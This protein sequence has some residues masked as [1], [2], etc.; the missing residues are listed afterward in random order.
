MTIRYQKDGDT[1][2]VQVN[3]DGATELLSAVRPNDSTAGA[4][5]KARN[6][7]GTVCI[8]GDKVP[9]DVIVRAKGKEYV[10]DSG[11]TN[12]PTAGLVTP[13]L[14]RVRQGTEIDEPIEQ[15]EIS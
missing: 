1:G 13:I 11:I 14:T 15:V 9:Y 7:S 4:W 10:V 2:V 8:P 6:H 5:V 3:C 12:S